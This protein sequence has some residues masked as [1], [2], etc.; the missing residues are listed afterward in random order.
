M[1]SLTHILMRILRHAQ[2]AI[3][4]YNVCPWR[5]SRILF[6]AQK[7]I[8]QKL[9]Y[10]IAPSFEEWHLQVN[11]N[12]LK[13]QQIYCNRGVPTYLHKLWKPWISVPR[14]ALFLLAPVFPLQDR[15]LQLRLVN[16]VLEGKWGW[17]ATLVSRIECRTSLHQR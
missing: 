12:I 14:L 13:E 15:Q 7:S 5:F 2:W 8:A 11:K 4:M 3:L 10:Q 17:M 1:K 16:M 6:I 9:I